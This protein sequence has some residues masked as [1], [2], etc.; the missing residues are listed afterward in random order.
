VLAEYAVPQFARCDRYG[1]RSRASALSQ[2]VPT[3]LQRAI[4]VER[5]AKFATASRGGE[6]P[7]NLPQAN[8]TGKRRKLVADED[9]DWVSTD[10]AAQLLNLSPARV[11]ELLEQGELGDVEIDAHGVVR[12]ERA[13]VLLRYQQMRR[14]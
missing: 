5:R 2:A 10:A 12:L 14:R 6:M 4:E 3:L 11:R 13:V 1:I 7:E 9:N 8:A